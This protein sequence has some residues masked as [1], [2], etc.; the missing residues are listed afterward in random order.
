MPPPPPP[1]LKSLA[2]PPL[3]PK[4]VPEPPD[5]LPPWIPAPPPLPP[6]APPPLPPAGGGQPAAPPFVLVVPL[7]DAL[8]VPD[9]VVQLCAHA[10]SATVP[11]AKP[12]AATSTRTCRP[13]AGDAPTPP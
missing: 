9:V 11:N 6:P 3:P 2:L 12:N 7:H 1:P 10:G 8:I 13:A 4:T 5:A